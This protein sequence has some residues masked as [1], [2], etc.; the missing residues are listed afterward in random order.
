MWLG[1]GR[2]DSFDLVPPKGP[3]YSAHQE[4]DPSDKIHALFKWVGASFGRRGVRPD[5]T[6]S[7]PARPAAARSYANSGFRSHSW[8]TTGLPLAD[9]RGGGARGGHRA[10]RLLQSCGLAYCPHGGTSHRAR[11]AYRGL[12]PRLRRHPPYHG[13]AFPQPATPAVRPAGLGLAGSGRG[14]RR[15]A[16]LDRGVRPGARGV[17]RPLRKRRGW[18]GR[19]GAP[20]C[21]EVE[22]GCCSPVA[23]LPCSTN[24]A[25]GPKNPLP[26]PNAPQLSQFMV[27]WV[28]RWTAVRNNMADPTFG[29]LC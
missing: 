13:P 12:P 1:K 26:A 27:T 15:S 25:D 6:V 28:P 18:A 29:N 22:A 20:P 11:G 17:G 24:C 19:T 16:A 7:W 5:G 2:P 21:C 9:R 10:P 4:A 23:K 14:F 3:I 8:A